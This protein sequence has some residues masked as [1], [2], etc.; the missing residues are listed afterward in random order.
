MDLETEEKEC[1][2][3]FMLATTYLKCKN[4]QEKNIK[5]SPHTLDSHSL[6]RFML[7]IAL[8]Q[9]KGKFKLNVEQ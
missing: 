8:H 1:S 3:A 4:L 7:C 5:T 6:S 9:D 2:S